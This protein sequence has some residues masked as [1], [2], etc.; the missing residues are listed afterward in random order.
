MAASYDLTLHRGDTFSR[1][2]TVRN[3]D[4]SPADL[5][6]RVF[7]APLTHSLSLGAV[8]VESFLIT[9]T[10]TPGQV[11]ISLTAA[12]TESLPDAAYW[13]L[14]EVDGDSVRTLVSG[15]VQ[16]SYAGV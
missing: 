9:P 7:F 11:R 10:A 1:T 5:A 8:A 2:L 3:E 14:R 4:G 16:T 12:E 6:G 15:L 13:Q